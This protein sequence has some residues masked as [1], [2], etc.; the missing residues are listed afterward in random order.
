MVP[1]A[2]TSQHWKLRIV[3]GC[4]VGGSP[5]CGLC[6]QRSLNMSAL[7]RCPEEVMRAV[8]GCRYDV[9]LAG[10]EEE[11]LAEGL[12]AGRERLYDKGQSKRI[13]GELYKVVDSSDVVIQV[14]CYAY[15]CLPCAMCPSVRGL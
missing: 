2:V 5:G 9:R 12:R 13:W 14:A 4:D 10:D 15:L 6:P 7:L 8:L 1:L 3:V 11:G